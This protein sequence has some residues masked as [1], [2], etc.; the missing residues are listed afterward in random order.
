MPFP[1]H[2]LSSREQL[3]ALLEKV[4]LMPEDDALRIDLSGAIAGILALCADTKK[5]G[6]EI[7]ALAEQLEVVA[8]ARN[9]HYLLF[10][11][12]GLRPVR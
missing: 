12:H 2:R 9:H 5:P 8:G 7:R 10:V 4:E 3:R 11:F 1:I 6:R